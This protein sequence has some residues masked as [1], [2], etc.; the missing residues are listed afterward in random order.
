MSLFFI[1]KI[2]QFMLNFDTDVIKNLKLGPPGA[3]LFH[4]SGR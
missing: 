3:D 4:D 1:Y 2:K